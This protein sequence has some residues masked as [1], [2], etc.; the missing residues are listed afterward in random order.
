[1]VEMTCWTACTHNCVVIE[2]SEPEQTCRKSFFDIISLMNANKF[3]RLPVVKNKELIGIITTYDIIRALNEAST[4][5]DVVCLDVEQLM[6]LDP[7]TISP[8]SSMQEA[9]KIMA[10]NMIGCLP[11]ISNKTLVGIITERDCLDALPTTREEPIKEICSSKEIITVNPSTSLKKGIE[12]MAE[13]NIRHL[14]IINS[15]GSIAGIITATD[16]IYSLGKFFNRELS[17]NSWMNLPVELLATHKTFMLPA[18]TPINL[19]NKIMQLNNIGAFPIIE[20]GKLFGIVSE[21]DI[22]KLIAET[23]E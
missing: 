17:A 21:R 16:I 14:I 7:I 12:T 8:N 19:V 4:L 20:K 9:A 1:M 10:S 2:T 11:I 18:D 23:G 6:T 5:P 13:E 3:R 15:E 22:V